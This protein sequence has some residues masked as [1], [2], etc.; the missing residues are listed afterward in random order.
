MSVFPDYGDLPYDSN[1][2]GRHIEPAIDLAAYVEAHWPNPNNTANSASTV[3]NNFQ[4]AAPDQHGTEF[5][6]PYFV[7]CHGSLKDIDGFSYQPKPFSMP[8]GQHLILT[9]FQL[10]S[11]QN[12]LPFTVGVKIDHFP[13]NSPMIGSVHDKDMDIFI[14]SKTP[15]RDVNHLLYEENQ[16]VLFHNG[17]NIASHWVGQTKETLNNTVLVGDDPNVM[18]VKCETP[19]VQAAMQGIEQRLYRPLDCVMGKYRGEPAVVIA[20]HVG[21]KCMARILNEVNEL[22]FHDPG[23]L[24]ISFKKPD[25]TKFEDLVNFTHQKDPNAS[26]KTDLIRHTNHHSISIKLNATFRV[27]NPSSAKER[28]SIGNHWEGDW[29]QQN[30]YPSGAYSNNDEDN[31]NEEEM[32][33]YPN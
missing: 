8:Q 32:G 20:K 33:E 17:R 23:K 27:Y 6:V 5:T 22:P 2:V 3:G 24:R 14:A 13:V 11:E 19:L 15:T 7:S 1:N 21:E 31:Y 12:S 25:G 4:V 18:I 30:T 10:V 29:V 28:A 9:K 16:N 26:L